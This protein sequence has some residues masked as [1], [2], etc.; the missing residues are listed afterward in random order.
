MDEKNLEVLAIGQPGMCIADAYPAQPFQARVS[1]IAPSVDPQRGTVD[2]RLSLA[3]TPDFLRQNMTVSVNVEASRSSPHWRPF[4]KPSDR[5]SQRQALSILNGLLNWL[6][7][8]GYLAGNPLA[9]RSREFVARSVKTSRFHRDAA[10]LR[11]GAMTHELWKAFHQ[12]VEDYLRSVTLADLVERHLA[13]ENVLEETPVSAPAPNRRIPQK[14][15]LPRENVP[16]LV[17]ALGSAALT[18]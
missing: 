16:N 7:Q 3:S 12:T 10:M 14:R 4:A 17:F 8:A 2:I 1:F 15:Q 9:L 5:P 13:A 6:V 18:R 11:Q